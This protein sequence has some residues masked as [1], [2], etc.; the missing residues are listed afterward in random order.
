[1]VYGAKAWLPIRST[2]TKKLFVWPFLVSWPGKTPTDA[3]AP[4]MVSFY[5]VMPT[6]CEAAGVQPP[7]GRNLG[8]RSFLPIVK[9]DPLPKKQPWRNVVFGEFRNTMMARDR[10]F[11][12]VLRNEGKGPNELVRLIE[13]SAREGQPI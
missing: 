5:D 9:Q 1:M 6:L 7:D 8:G 4:E 3:M 2:C 10:R 12:V 11:K 13:G